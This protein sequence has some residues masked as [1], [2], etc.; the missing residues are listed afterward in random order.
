MMSMVK[1]V[2]RRVLLCFLLTSLLILSGISGCDSDK[3]KQRELYVFAAMSLSDALTEIGE[4]FTEHNDIGV[5]YNFAASSTLQRQIE[6]GASAGLFISASPIQVDALKTLDLLEDGSRTDV[7]TNRLVIVSQKNTNIKIE[8]I[9]ELLDTSLKRIAIGHPEI[10]PAGNYAKE[11]LEHSGLWV[12]VKPKLIL[13]TNVRATLAY[14]TSGNVD[15]AI[16]YETDAKI[17]NKVKVL[18]KF[19]NETHSRIVYPAVILKNSNNQVIAKT[20]LTFLK[21]SIATDIFEQHGFTCLSP[22]T[23]E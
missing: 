8:N 23:K 10:V 9:A 19:P 1:I 4:Q 14:L 11:A 15:I 22:T 3:Q 18:F 12:K 20:F 5:H 2:R 16:V 6:K 7:L 21:D 13:G 17:T